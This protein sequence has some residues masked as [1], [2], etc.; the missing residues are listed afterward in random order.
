MSAYNPNYLKTEVVPY[1]TFSSS[2]A[3][4]VL[5]KKSNKYF[6]D[7]GIWRKYIDSHYSVATNKKRRQP[8]CVAL[9]IDLNSL[10][11]GL[12]DRSWKIDTEGVGKEFQLDD[13]YY[14]DNVWDHGHMAQ[15]SA[16]SWGTD[17][18]KAQKARDE[19]FYHTNC[20]LQHSNH[21][22]D[23]WVKVEN[24]VKALTSDEKK[25]SVFVGPIYDHPDIKRR[26]LNSNKEDEDFVAE[27]PDGFFKL[28]VFIN[29]DKNLETKGYL[30]LQTEDAIN[31]TKQ[32]IQNELE[33]LRNADG[34]KRFD[35]YLVATKEI[36]LFTGLVFDKKL[37][38]SN[39]KKDFVDDRKR[40]PTPIRREGEPF[41]QRSVFIVAL[42]V[43]PI[44]NERTNERVYIA[45]NSTKN[46]DLSGW[47]ISDGVRTD[48]SFELSGELSTGIAE[49][50]SRENGEKVQLTN[51]G[52]SLTL[53][54]PEGRVVDIV[55]W[56]PQDN[57]EIALFFAT[58]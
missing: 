2:L 29:K 25:V 21:N 43:N 30:S 7:D 58:S 57:G 56:G 19:T 54:D 53:K 47:T 36:E 3:D 10:K 33:E 13:S 40:P 48:K 34:K 35:T 28:I 51:S 9:N 16:A 4:Q 32:P 37:H 12:K 17:R 41:K 22:G 55:E 26:T 6:T 15:K 24:R 45:N 31:N 39:K 27:I 11:T 50:N 8:I 46:V 18:Q 38:D 49:F 44:E 20:C 1:P 23:E 14:D 42:V 52:G 5:V